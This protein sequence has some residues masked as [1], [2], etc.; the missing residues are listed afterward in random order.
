MG[1]ILG[2]EPVA[3]A[4]VV[5]IALNLALTFGLDLDPDQVA[6]INALV[7]GVLALLARQSVFPTPT[8][9]TIANA[10]TFEKPGT[11]IDIGNPPSGTP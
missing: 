9:Q 11:I 6:L 3:I 1:T 8:V 10:S 7:V 4:A 5:G 2:R